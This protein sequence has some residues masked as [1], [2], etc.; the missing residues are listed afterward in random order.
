MNS[1]VPKTRR[2]PRGDCLAATQRPFLR[3]SGN[4]FRAALLLLGTLY[5]LIF[6]TSA[7]G[8]TAAVH[9]GPAGEAGPHSSSGH[10]GSR[11]AAGAGRCAN[12]SQGNSMCGGCTGHGGGG[13]VK[14]T[15]AIVKETP[16]VVKETPSVVKEPSE[17]KETAGGGVKASKEVV[18]A[19]VP[20]SVP[21]A[22]ATVPPPSARSTTTAK[23]AAKKTVKRT[24]KRLARKKHVRPSGGTSERS[25]AR[26]P[27]PNKRAAF[28]G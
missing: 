20:A 24:P 4:T 8:A 18:P 27:L 28:T 21:A 23:K 17:V 10:S 14:E 6:A 11:A 12:T 9:S 7:L 5:T 3:A 15:P 16:S 2:S 25:F 13:E 19:A 1:G 26:S 22:V